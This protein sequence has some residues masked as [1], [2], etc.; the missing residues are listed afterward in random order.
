MIVSRSAP[1]I[2]EIETVFTALSHQARRHI[3]LILSHMGGELP[4]GY[5]A[6]RFH[7]Q[8]VGALYHSTAPRP[9]RRPKRWVVQ[10][11][12]AF[13]Q[14]PQMLPNRFYRRVRCRLPAINWL[15]MVCTTSA[16]FMTR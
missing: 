10:P 4:S 15:Y 5:L 1:S 6:A 14:V 2:E 3:L 8:F 13:R 7:H 9:P 11:R 12:F 16:L